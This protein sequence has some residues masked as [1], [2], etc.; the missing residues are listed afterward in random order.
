MGGTTAILNGALYFKSDQITITG[1][2]ASGY[3]MLVAD[4]IYI[5]GNSN[6]A[7]NGDPFD[8]VTVSVSPASAGLNAGQT[9]QFT[10]TVANSGNSAVTWTISPAGSGTISTA[11]LY[12]APSS[13]TTQ[14]TVTVTATSQDDSSKAG[15]ATI[16]LYPPVVVS[17]SPTA[18]TLYSG[19]TQQFAATVT[20]NSN[21]A[22]TW[23]ISPAGTGTISSAGL[24]TAPASVASSQ[25]VTVTATS[26][27]NTA[28]SASATITLSPPIAVSVSPT[29]ATL[30][31][32]QTQQFAAT[33]TN[34]S[35]TAVTWAISPVGTGTI[36]AAGLYTAPASVAS[37]QNVTVTAT[38]VANT[39]KS[40]SA[41][42]MLSPPVAVSVS[43]TAATLYGGQTQQFS[44]TVMNT[45]NTAVMWAI[46]PAGTGTI[47]PAGLY[48]APTNVTAAQSVTVTATSAANSA[49]TATATVML[50]PPVSVSVSPASATLYGGQSQQFSANVT[51]SSNTSVTWTISPA[52]TGTISAAGL[53]T[54]PAS[55][56]SSQNITVT[57]TSVANTS[58]SASAI[59]SLSPPISV[60][61]VT[62]P[63]ATLFGGQSQQFGA[64]VVNTTNQ[65][66]TWTI[67]PAA[68]GTITASGVYTAPSTISTLQTVTVVATSIVSVSASGSATITLSPPVAVSV[69]PSTAT[70]Y[71]GQTE[72][73]AASVVNA[74]N[75]AVTWAISPSGVGT[76][77]SNG[78]YAA[79]STITGQQSVTVIATSVAMPTATASATVTLTA[80]SC[81][82]N[83][84]AFERMIVVD[85]TKVATADQSNFPF[86]FSTT[87]PAFKSTANGGHITNSNGYDIF[88][89]LDP[90]GLSK[91]DF[92]LQQYDPA[93]GQIVAWM[94]IPMLSHTSDT[95]VY[96]FYGN[97]SISAPE[98]NPVGVWDSNFQGVYHLGSLTSSTVLDST[99]NANNGAAT[100]VTQTTGQIAGAA[101]FNGSTSYIQLPGG[102]T[103]SSPRTISAW[104]NS[105]NQAG[106]IYCSGLVSSS[107]YNQAFSLYANIREAGNVYLQTYG[108]DNYTAAGTAPL[109]T[110]NYVTLSYSGGP[111]TYSS[112][113]L[114]VNGSLV[115][116]YEGD[117]NTGETPNTYNGNFTIG[118]DPAIN[119]V[120]FGGSI[121]EVEV[122]NS[123]RSSSWILAEYE[124][125]SSPSTFYSLTA[126][127]TVA[128]FPSKTGLYAS[129]SLQ[130]TAVPVST[131]KNS[132][133]WSISPAGAG[134]ITSSGLYTAPSSIATEQ[135]VTITAVPPAGTANA[136]V[137]T[138]VLLPDTAQ[139][140]LVLT[141]SAAS[142]Y[143]TGSTQT[144]VATRTDPIGNSEAGLPVIFTVS[145]A[146]PG[147][148]EAVTDTSGLATFTYSGTNSG[149][150]T[151]LASSASG[152]TTVVSNSVVA[153]WIPQSAPTGQ[154]S[155]V[156]SPAGP[157]PALGLTGLLGAFTDSTGAVIEPVVL[158]ASAKVLIV[159]AGATQLQLGVDDDIFYDNYGSGFLVDVNGVPVTVPPTAMPWIWVAGGLNNNY[160]FGIG[161]GSSPI[162]GATNLIAGQGVEVSYQSGTVS[163]GFG[164][165]PLVNADGDLQD[166][167]GSNRGNSG[168][169]HPTYYMYDLTRQVGET[170]AFSALVED[171][172]ANPVANTTA[173]FSV[174]G[175]NAQQ[176]TA[177][178]DG[179]GVATAS[180]TGQ[181][182][183]TDV[184][185]VSATPTGSTAITSS[186]STV[187]WTPN[188]TSSPTGNLQLTPA[189]V[190][191]AV[192]GGNLVLTI[193][194]RDSSGLPLA[195]VGVGVWISGADNLRF[196]AVTGS[197]G[198]ATVT[199]QNVNAGTS[200]IQSIALI[201]GS[202]IYSNIVDTTWI[203]AGSGSSGS[204]ALINI[205]VLA[206]TTVTL[207]NVL[208][209][210]ATVTDSSSLNNSP[211]LTWSQL[212]GPGVT[213]F[214]NPA[215][216]NTTAAF[217]VAGNYILQLAAS[218]GVNSASDQVAI[219]VNSSAGTQGWIGSPTY[220]STVTGVVPVTLSPGVALTSGR[221][222]YYAA[223]DTY[224]T[225]PIVLN[226]NVTGTGTIGTFD[227]TLLSNGSYYL[228][229]QAIDSNGQSQY[230]ISLVTVAGQYKPGR[231]TTT[232]TD[233]VVPA[234]GL[235][236]NIQRRYDSLNAATSS[237]FGYGWSLGI[238]TDLAVDSSY[239]VTF[240]LG[241]QRKTFYFTPQYQ[242]FFLG[243]VGG[244]TPEPGFAGSLTAIPDETNCPFNYI[245]PEGSLWQ[246]G[247]G[248][249]YS[250]LA[251]IYTDPSGTQYSISSSGS[252]Q[253]I[254]DIGGN[255]L[256]VTPAGIASSSGLLVVPFVRDASGRITKITDPLGHDYSYGY[257][258]SGNLASVTYPGV[259]QA[260]QY[261]YDPHHLYLSGTDF[262]GNKLPTSTYDTNGRLQTVTDGLGETTS[263]AYN[264]A[265][266]TTVVTYPPDANGNVGTAAMVYDN[267]GLL[268]SSTDP[269]GHTTTNSYDPNHNLISVTDPLGHTNAYTY[270][271]LGNRITSTYPQT[272]TSTNTTSA[273]TYN[274]YSEPTA[275]MDELGNVRLYNY[276][277][278]SWP[279]SVT[280][281]LG[282][283]L[284][285][286]FNSN[287][288][289]LAGAIGYDITTQPTRA[290]QFMYD[291]DGNRTST[292]DALGR[293][294]RYTYDNL[295]RKLT[296]IEP[297]PAGGSEV[298]ATTNYQYDSLGNLVQTAAPLGRTTSSTYD[299]NNNKVSDT[300]ARGNVTTY[301]YDSLNRL[302]TT[303]YPTTPATTVTNTYDFRG[304]VLTV[305]DQA[306][307]VTQ[308]Q[309]D[310][311]GRLTSVTKAY[312]T[313]NATTTSYAYYADGR[314]QSETDS[315]GHATTYT[316][317]AA[318]HLIATAGV[319]GTVQYGYDNAGNQVS[320]TDANGH[321]TQYQYD[322]RKRLVQTTYPDHTTTTNA[323]DGPGNLTGVTDQAGNVVNY[324][325]D[326]ANQL[327]T[328]VQTASPSAQ[329]TTAYGYDP[330]GNLASSSDANSHITMNGYDLLSEITAKTLPD[331]SL[332][333]TRTY[334]A[335]GNLKTLTHFNGVTTTYTYDN[336]NRLISQATPGEVTVGHTYTATGK[337]LTTTDASGTTN[338]AYDSM[339]RL[340]AKATPE[341]TLNYTFNAI[342]KVANI[343]SSNVNGASMAYTY[344]SLDQLATVV[345]NRLSAG[346]NTTTYTY[347]AANNLATAT[348][349]NGLKSTF[350][351]D[352]LNRLTELSTPPIADYSYSLGVTGLR[353]GVTEQSGRTANWTYDG[354]YRLTNEAISLSPAG[355]N[356]SVGYGLDPVGNR[357]TE[358]SS[359]TGLASGSFTFNADDQLSTETYDA[360]GNTLTSG[361]KS[362][363]YDA[364]NKLVSM[365]GGAVTIAYDGF[366]NRVAKT[367]G[368]VTTRYLVED[369]VNPTGYPQ[370]FDEL[371]GSTVT[372]T[373]TYG[374]Q[375][376]DEEQIIG[377]TWT[378]S[379]YGYD[380]F[381]NVRQ[382]TNVSGTVTDTY[383]YDAFGHTFTTSG[384]TP[385][386]YLYRGEQY[387]SDLG[388]HYLRARYY[389]SA[390]GTFVS[391]DPIDTHST[392][393]DGTP[394][395]PKSLHKYLYA[396][397][398]PING[399]DPT[400]R[401]ELVETVLV[402]G[403]SKLA[404]EDYVLSKTGLT[405][406]TC[407]Y[408]L[409]RSLY[410]ITH[411]QSFW[412]DSDGVAAIV[413]CAIGLPLP[414]VI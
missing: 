135:T 280:D 8:G 171:G 174:T 158:G 309:Y 100:N 203:A 367:V 3:T 28:K 228:Q 36:S 278:N 107:P 237:D 103:G 288:Q 207:P 55:V 150:D 389:N 161:D 330:L 9:Q 235:A 370:V 368:G 262:R 273:T 341:G 208:Q 15:S 56:T 404:V 249:P 2:N 374:L 305:T 298:A 136:T 322:A 294:T 187:I 21:T 313:A 364:E 70:L 181:L 244:Y 227:T 199:Y 290:S 398:D 93:T 230:S 62:P 192:A 115:S 285:S 302:V 176:L 212:A 400:G 43:P 266:N 353:T 226:A 410:T 104:V 205:S 308:N 361:G 89:C 77:D 130:F 164:G 180:Y 264:L 256:T 383:E 286:N 137:A 118:L 225:S 163:A 412:N 173:T 160:Q 275:S 332:Q 126:E 112:M 268:L 299:S 124:N 40:A 414:P 64:T 152:G 241:G 258:T 340:T 317:D 217:S 11:G 34:S 376:I 75:T 79:P 109:N 69:A 409:A 157:P 211:I 189:S 194:A 146:N 296:M 345:D 352:A 316:Y 300:D 29:A 149:S 232:V 128:I 125:Q 201:K 46:S 99:A 183:G 42:I 277:A 133:A 13:V 402:E 357:Q 284:S 406:A 293:V 16:T 381:G 32:G 366:G 325:F 386:N 347:D 234:T 12:T 44:A 377:S 375:R 382:L 141:A 379:F 338:Y 219:S 60:S 197:T 120:P 94:R 110:W 182:A 84:Y 246:C 200:T 156:L 129:Q 65:T 209:L 360:N 272:A 7:T 396:G 169:H 223:N 331:G 393:V 363:A 168:T 27:A 301:Q 87:D 245:I 240:T 4:K 295:G 47:S 24:Y 178:T 310:L 143:T 215:L 339:D 132:F 166:I 253:S 267:Y 259:A 304:N 354:I 72:Q 97:S 90:N 131:C 220:G 318:G 260:S 71:G 274:Q 38:S 61:G 411:D 92:E 356:G 365:N 328:V 202:V 335:A 247:T 254:E 45:S 95:V 116:N 108:S 167:T 25:N 306:G 257:D 231:V 191:P 165:Y 261:T 312:G 320:M 144:Y 83:G 102:I 395:D 287:G 413:G 251:Y 408:G 122:S 337:Y 101:S 350:T 327:Q 74:G 105:T 30:Y 401:E 233:L 281:G 289:M 57:A 355:N 23:T 41:T 291:S 121:E 250:P 392:E 76:I 111:T 348:Y 67:S 224:A 51:N 58:V 321:T 20:N 10:A 351:Y 50:S 390:T 85:H 172:S 315:L 188:L 236:I 68:V 48:T 239:N 372:R 399:I 35:N 394:T 378:P 179:N 206:D 319:K 147:T 388:L 139:S 333:E 279:S 96:M 276:D 248:A 349:P 148:H 134:T 198:K 326:A 14:Q 59:I 314:K 270:D 88:F 324:T 344:D 195:Q 162:I 387:D 221:L 371:T 37:S 403:G 185:Q 193:M 359:I 204:G 159:P 52:G 170:I 346:Q 307:N 81:S 407:F 142:P 153:T 263:Y 154:Y 114:Y 397:G 385:N 214:A 242:Y 184:V 210:N 86:L 119:N 66:V 362:F 252:L 269:L 106:C 229:L 213:T 127:N 175:A 218:D 222:I 53:Y 196:E 19:Q 73:F 380:G 238:N 311:A 117:W 292:T 39:A 297:Y 369:D 405:V 342:G 265:T 1:S 31:G 336:L 155:I 343:A 384:S 26:V 255:T 358:T 323:Y 6:F 82:S 113:S 271:L 5:N 33:V 18:A 78:L 138:V 145:G 391:R 22:V 243:Y 334:D 216:A 186:A 177:T 49:A 373:Y 282:V 303:T 140:T 190:G 329:N 123:A 63:T 54:A 91:L 17:V 80:A 151:I 283:L 98:F